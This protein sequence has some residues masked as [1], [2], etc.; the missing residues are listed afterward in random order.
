MPW[1]YHI[2]QRSAF[3]AH[4]RDP[5]HESNFSTRDCGKRICTH[6]VRN[7]GHPSLPWASSNKRNIRRPQIRDSPE[8][9]GQFFFIRLLR[10]NNHEFALCKRYPWEIHVQAHWLNF[11]IAEA[12][13]GW[14]DF[15]TA[16]KSLLCDLQ[17]LLLELQTWNNSVWYS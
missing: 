4:S 8:V 1:A 2:V 9:H 10:D 12:S 7:L 17:S 5:E 13:Q 3:K 11:E 6:P 16:E 15:E 14:L